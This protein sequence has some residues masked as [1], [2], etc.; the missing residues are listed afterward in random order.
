MERYRAKNR[1]SASRSSLPK[2]SS[3]DKSIP[4]RA[5]LSP[6]ERRFPPPSIRDGYLSGMSSM[7]GS[8]G[9]AVPRPPMDCGPY[10]STYPPGSQFTP[11]NPMF[12]PTSAFPSDMYGGMQHMLVGSASS[13]Y[14]PMQPSQA[15]QQPSDYNMQGLQPGPMLGDI[16]PAEHRAYAAARAETK[17]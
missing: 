16:A 4:E 14:S 12:T 10:S 9:I 11:S 6:D 2:E 17:H 7:G 3:K 8:M 15:S 1:K 13:L 5:F